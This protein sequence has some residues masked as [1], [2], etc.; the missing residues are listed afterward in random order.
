[1]TKRTNDI[2]NMRLSG[3]TLQAIGDKYNITRERVRQICNWL[4]VTKPSRESPTKLSYDERTKDRIL[5]KIEKTLNGCWEWTGALSK[6]GY[7]WFSYKGKGCYGHRAS[8]QV[9]NNVELKN[10]GRNTFHTTCVLHRCDN[11]KCVNPEHLFLGTQDDNMKDR[12][13]KNRGRFKKKELSLN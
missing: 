13:F 4:E 2:K 5:K 7:S 9:F 6:K 3:M 1:M 8:Y 12:D 11:P 10:E